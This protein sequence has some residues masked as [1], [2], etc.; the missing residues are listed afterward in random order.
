[1]P[2]ALCLGWALVLALTACLAGPALAQDEKAVYERARKDYQ[3]LVGHEQ[4]RRVYQNWQGLYD[5]FASVYAADPHGA[6]APNCL[7]W[8][9][10]VRSGAWAQFQRQGD[11]VE[12]VDLFRRFTNHFPR[13]RLADDAQMRLGELYEQAG[14]PK[15][16][17]LEYLRVTVN[18]PKGDMVPEA[19][20]RLD[21]LEKTLRPT[22]GG[23]SIVEEAQ[24]GRAPAPRPE[25]ETE[26]VAAVAPA[27]QGLDPSLAVLGQVRH[28]STP[29][30][31]RVV[32]GL[33][34]PV[35][36]STNLLTADQDAGK[37]RR[38]YVDLRGAQIA[39]SVKDL[40]TIDDGLLAAARAGQFT[41]DT[42]R[43]VLDINHLVS[44]KIFTLDNPFRVVV[45][46]FGEDRPAPVKV[47]TA[48][49]PRGE[50]AHPASRYTSRAHKVPR[51]RATG[52]TGG[53]GLA[54]QLGLGVRRVVVDPGH[55]G[56]DPGCIWRGIKEKDLTLDIAKRV[57]E[58]LRKKAGV[59]VLL[60]RGKDVTVPLEE[61]T[62]FANTRE[63][64]LF[65]SIHINAAAS[66][67]LSGIETYFLNLAADE[68][69]VR[70][71][72]RENATTQRSINDLQLILKDLMLSS[73]INESNRLAHA[74]QREL[75][76]AVR[77]QYEVED[78]RVKQAP[79]IVLIGARM[80]AVMA[81]VGFITNPKEHQRLTNPAYRDLLAEGIAAGVAA[82]ARQLRQG[83]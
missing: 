69:S 42:V 9:G 36:Y 41:P 78:L 55:G 82:Y 31:T 81:E 83:S 33:D 1:M 80:P 60:T 7:W 19:K 26:T 3:W 61:R 58:K 2:R 14:D 30:Y 20:Q 45:D 39:G 13:S 49:S 40:V 17:Y 46:C 6:L 66:P 18:Y 71:A 68:E 76:G 77:K 65:V 53:L 4:G 38:L 79:F 8:M 50:P 44:Y 48:K 54:A 70:V 59:E 28:W 51:G 25:P 11:F 21:A 67:K 15:Q 12:A 16:A 72:A 43:V 35:P 5:R 24:R 23:G 56:K 22:L 74:L 10:R 34:R 62:A 37:P 29:S 47:K 63:A 64:D 52:E 27:A 57:A 32:L 73:K 75:I